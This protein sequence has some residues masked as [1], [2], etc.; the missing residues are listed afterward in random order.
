MKLI[1][2]ANKSRGLYNTA[3]I[4]MYEASCKSKLDYITFPDLFEK[5]CRNFSI[6]KSEAWDY[7]KMFQELGF[8]KIIPYHGVKLNFEVRYGNYE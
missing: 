4:R 7:V 8:L 1:I 6:N 3:L 2:R 5:L